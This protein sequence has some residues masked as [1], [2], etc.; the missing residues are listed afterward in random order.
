M[1]V[2]KLFDG[3]RCNLAGTLVELNDTMG[4]EPPDLEIWGLDPKPKLAVV[5]L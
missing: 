5:Y 4:P 3:F 2:L 1:H